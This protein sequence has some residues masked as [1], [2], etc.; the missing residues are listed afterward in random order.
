MFITI[1]MA[2]L[3]GVL[4]PQGIQDS[5]FQLK[6]VEIRAGE[7]FRKEEAGMSMATI[8]SVVLAEKISLGLSELLSENTLAFVKNYGRGAL[9]TVSFRGAAASHTNVLWNGLPI[10]SPMTGMADFSL[11]P[12]YIV[13]DLEIRAG[14][15]SIAQRSGGLGGSV[16]I[17]SRV[18]WQNKLGVKFLQGVGSYRTFNEFLQVTAGNAAFQ[19]KTRAYYNAS[20]NNYTFINRGIADIDPATGEVTNPLDTNDH[21]DYRI[22]GLLQEFFA[23]AGEK[24]LLSLK[25]WYQNAI[26]TLPRATSYEGPDNSNLNRHQQQDHKLA[27]DWKRY[28]GQ[29]LLLVRSGFVYDDLLYT[30]RN[31]VP[32]LGQVPAI[33]S[34]SRQMG[35]LNRLAYTYD[36]SESF[37]VEASLDADWRWVRSEDTVS[38]AGYRKD[39]SDL[40][41]FLAARKSVGERLNLNLMLRQD[42]SDFKISPF[43]PYLGFD[44]SILRNHLLVL[45]GNIARNYHLP[46]LNDLYW[47]PG[48][49]PEL[50]PEKGYSY[51]LG[52]EYTMKQ[53]WHSL[54]AGA[55]FF[56]SDIR[57][58]IIWLPGFK[59]Y[60]EPVN[61]EEVRAT[62]FEFILDAKGRFGQLTYHVLGNYAFTRS[63]NYGEPKVWGDESYGKQL[64]YIPV[65]SGNLMVNISMYG[66]FIAYQHNSYSKRYTTSSNDLTER[67][68]IYPYYMNDLG[69]GK[70]FRMKNLSLSLEFKVYNLFNET[71]HSV[72]YRPMPGRNYML[73]LLID[74]FKK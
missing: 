67:G 15:A 33:Y 65:H 27:V 50:L 47:Q 40:S 3:T 8:D 19:S 7:E 37:S 29:S 63:V 52:S 21:A 17:T 22:Y 61:I 39:R 4:Y 49:N 12:V 68:S 23:K 44:F 41:L 25:Y 34:L 66:F 57:N 11:I 48:G 54:R 16:S 42:W 32:G 18:D 74:L 30:L 35:W 45:K 58:W 51:E 56:R 59:G 9:A 2:M 69:A 26:R 5:V 24:N 36:I 1:A 71:Y 70:G 13:D 55:T 73:V 46:S 64:P 10:S 20:S 43:M 60:W 72:L 53:E 31:T 28:G 38:G 6:G 62:G 14:P